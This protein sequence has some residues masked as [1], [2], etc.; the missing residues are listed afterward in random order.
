MVIEFEG[1]RNSST[2][3]NEVSVLYRDILLSVAGCSQSTFMPYVSAI[4]TAPIINFMKFFDKN[5]YIASMQL[6][7]HHPNSWNSR[8]PSCEFV[9]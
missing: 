5:I 7:S 1:T 3:T 9:P 6:H 8:E 2:M 4:D